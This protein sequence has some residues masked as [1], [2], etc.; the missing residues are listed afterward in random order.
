MTRLAATGLSLLLALVV[1][2]GEDTA[3]YRV[4]GGVG[5]SPS[6][7]G[8]VSGMLPDG[9]PGDGDATAVDPVVGAEVVV[10]DQAG[11]EIHLPAPPD[12][13]V[14]LVPAATGVVLALGQGHR[15]V[16]RTDYDRDP[17]L[18]AIPSVGGGLHPSLE[19]LASLEPGIVIRFEGD[20]D[21]ATPSALDRAGIPHLAVRP[22]RLD[23]VFAMIELVG[24][25]LDV[26]ARAEA[27][28]EELRGELE[29][30]RERVGERTPVRTLFLLGGDPPW[31]AGPGTFIHELVEIAGGR[32]VLVEGEVPLYG[33]MSVEEIVQR[34]VDLLL[35]PEGGQ[36]PSGLRRFEVMRVS[37]DVQSPGVG[38]GGAARELSRALH[39]EV[40]E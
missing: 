20:Q 24:R 27:L 7:D 22:D 38:L 14:S 35:I 39:P 32:N 34:E 5:G 33:P 9:A 25:T 36:V 1:G 15:L 11:R 31:V 4:S 13:V 10:R 28:A 37:G 17:R 3:E 30:V 26:Q 23:D 18:E 12:R 6:A 19:R 16:G 8:T 21:R 2:C 29:T 40:W